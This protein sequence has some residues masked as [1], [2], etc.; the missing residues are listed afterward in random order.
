MADDAVTRVPARHLPALLAGAVVALQLVYPLAGPSTRH[1]LS[2]AIV[3][4]LALTCVVH[5]G[6]TRGP[7][8]AVALLA[9]TA[10]PGFAVEVLGVHTGFPFGAYA[11]SDVLGPRLFG[12]PPVVGLAWTMLAW[13]AGLAAR[14][15]VRGRVARV[16]VGAWALAV[17]DLF[18]DPQLVATGAWTWRFPSP[19][20]PGVPDVPL[21]NYAGWLLVALVL[22]AV[23]QAIA[24]EGSDVVPVAVY[25]WLYGGWTLALAAFLDLGAA[26]G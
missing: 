14:R 2:V 3:A 25:L 8:R 4:G 19:H 23:V 16:L 11:Y 26:A 10:V 13:P 20:L 21:T 6:L 22:S 7:G 1:H 5:A 12:V 9:G 24:G 18:L 17:A 15:L